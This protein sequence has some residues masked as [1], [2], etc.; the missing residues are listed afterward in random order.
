MWL[1]DS[2]RCQTHP[3]QI[4]FSPFTRTTFMTSTFF[5]DYTIPTACEQSIN[6]QEQCTPGVY[7]NVEGPFRYSGLF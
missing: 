2:P 3:V 5:Q 1:E 7:E 6:P 4:L